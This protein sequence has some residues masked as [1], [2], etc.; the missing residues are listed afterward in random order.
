M[1]NP[2]LVA[3]DYKN[4]VNRIH[5]ILDGPEEW[6]SETMSTVAEVLTNHGFIIR[7][8]NEEELFSEDEKETGIRDWWRHRR[9]GEYDL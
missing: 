6:D 7:D 5:A 2:K 3:L 1:E 8:P 9:E 4:I